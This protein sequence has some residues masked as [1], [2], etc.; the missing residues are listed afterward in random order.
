MIKYGLIK[1]KKSTAEKLLA[2]IEYEDQIWYS[3]DI[4]IRVNEVL[5]KLQ[6]AWMAEIKIS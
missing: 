1:F 5:Y 6:E 4:A 3:K 2:K